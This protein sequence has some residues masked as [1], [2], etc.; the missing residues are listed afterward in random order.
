MDLINF[1]HLLVITRWEDAAATL[2][3]L[4]ATI[5]GIIEVLD[6]ANITYRKAGT[7]SEDTKRQISGVL[8]IV[9][10]L[11]AY[12]LL[13]YLERTEYSLNGVALSAVFGLWA[14]KQIHDLVGRYTKK[15]TGAER[16]Q[17][18]AQAAEHQANA[19]H[20]LTG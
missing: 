19:P 13:G 15:A 4:G 5:F 12:F 11:A 8:A 20:K 10:P 9:L 2:L 16:L 1:L 14:A 3:T 18:A 6:W 17:R 7:I